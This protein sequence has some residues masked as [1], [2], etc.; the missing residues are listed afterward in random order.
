MMRRKLKRRERLSKNVF[1]EK[2]HERRERAER[3]MR[4]Q[5]SDGQAETERHR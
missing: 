1:E 4:R 2:L 3:E 5:N